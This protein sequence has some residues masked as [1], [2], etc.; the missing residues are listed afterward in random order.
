MKR[1]VNTLYTVT[2]GHKWGI[3]TTDLLAVYISWVSTINLSFEYMPY[4]ALMTKLQKLA[5]EEV[6][7]PIVP[8][9]Q[10]RN[11]SSAA[12]KF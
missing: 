12:A 8:I 6:G 7:D 3:L 10:K 5:R 11:S 1:L 9:E 2:D 4:Y